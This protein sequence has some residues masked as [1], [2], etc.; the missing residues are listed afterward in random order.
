MIIKWCL[1]A[2]KKNQQV[3]EVVSSIANNFNNLESYRHHSNIHI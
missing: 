3:N 2:K 1:I